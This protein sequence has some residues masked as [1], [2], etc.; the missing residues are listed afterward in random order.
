[1]NHDQHGASQN[2]R[3]TPQDVN[4]DLAPSW[5]EWGNIYRR[6]AESGEAKVIRNLRQDFA[7]AMAAAEA[8]KAI[9]KTLSDEHQKIV[10]D[11]F[12]RE[13]GKQGF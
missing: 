3:A 13:L 11:V 5:G 1:M 10:S 7:K 12:V 2:N 9:Q 6:F 8:L 4:I